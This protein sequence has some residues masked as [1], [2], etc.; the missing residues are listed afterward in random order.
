MQRLRAGACLEIQATPGERLA[1][2]LRDYAYLGD[3][4]SP[5]PAP[6][7]ADREL[8][9]KEVVQRWQTWAA[10]DNWRRCSTN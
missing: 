1:Y 3:D 7:G 10:R 5:G 6:G 2:L 8:H 9:G 4:P